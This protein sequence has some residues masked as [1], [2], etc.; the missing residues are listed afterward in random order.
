MTTGRAHLHSLR[1]KTDELATRVG[2]AAVTKETT[3]RKSAWLLLNVI[4]LLGG[5]GPERLDPNA[6]PNPQPFPEPFPVT[7]SSG[8]FL[9]PR[10]TTGAPVT[11]PVTP[12][13]ISGGTLLITH[14]GDVAIVSDPDRDRVMVVDLVAG[15]VSEETT[16]LPPG[17]EPGRIT[18]DADGDTHVVLRGSGDVFSFTPG[19]LA[20]GERHHVCAMPRGIAYDE[21]TDSL[22]VACRSG[23]LVTLTTDGE[24]TRAVQVE[25]DLRDVTIVDG[26]LFVSTFRQAHLLELDETGQPVTDR[27]PATFAGFGGARFEDGFGGGSTSSGF[28]PAVAWRTTAIPGARTI[29]MVHQRE[30]DTPVEPQPGGYGAS[31]GGSCGQSGIVQS[32][33]T[34]FGAD[35]SVSDGVE[36]PAATLP[37]D[38]AFSHDGNEV[39]VVAAGNES[40]V[41]SVQVFARSTLE[42]TG[43]FGC[44]GS[45]S[46]P[47]FGGGIDERGLPTGGIPNAIAAAYDGADR[48]V[49]QQREPSALVVA[50]DGGMRTIALGGESRFDTGHSVFHGNS[51]AFIACASCHPE[52]SDDGRTWNFDGIG[53][54]RTPALHG[55]LR[56]TEPFHWDGDMTDLGVLVHEVFTGRMSGPSLD[57][58]QVDALGGWLDALPAP[59]GENSLDGE[60]AARGQA[61]FYG[62]AHCGDCHSGALFTNNTTVDVGT[63]GRFQVPSLIGV[64]Y[65]LPLMHTGCAT[66]LRARFEAGC[67]GGDHHGQTSQLDEASRDDLIAFL[68]TL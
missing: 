13:A 51:G 64:S 47:R 28:Q 67:G 48:L 43:S 23:Q 62:E 52:G 29:A 7:P 68:E 27:V 42:A 57:A 45:M 9:D 34:F 44:V 2:V 38:I 14:L 49:V 10:I 22:H 19:A 55:D 8:E 18:E 37:V 40:G 41:F 32:A 3:M 50:M 33:V 26:R 61:I 53:D 16:S 36:I 17:S 25:S 66:S 31:G 11:L 5:C 63:G 65:R 56:G 12:P 46:D 39:A 1:R 4:A 30:S 35:G 24:I 54:R 6:Q 20:S 15:S 58:H 60:S 59:V 21:S